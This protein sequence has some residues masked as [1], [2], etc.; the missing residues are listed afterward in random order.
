MTFNFDEEIDRFNSD[1]SKWNT[2]G[3]DVIP[4]W[5][6]DMDFRS[7]P[8]IIDVLH[9]RIDHGVF[10][11]GK[12][13][14]G[15]KDVIIER[16]YRRYQWQI[17]PDW[18]VILPGIVAGLNL[19]VRAFTDSHQA[20]IAPEIIYPPFKTASSLAGRDQRLAP[21]RLHEQRWTIDLDA[22]ED[23]MEG[24]EK[25]LLLCNPQN[26]GGT[27][28]QRDE[29]QQQLNFAKKHDLIVCSDEI[30]SELILCE[31]S[32]HIPFATLGEDAAARS[33]TLVSP[34]KTFNIAGLGASCA[35]IPNPELR[36]RFNATRQGIVPNVDVLALTAAEAAWRDGDP[37]L[38]ALLTYLRAN[39]DIVKAAIDNLPGLHM[40]SPQA[41]YLAWIDARELQLDNPYNFFLKAGVGLS[42]GK[43]FGDHNFVRLN[44]GCTRKLLTQ[45]LLRLSQAVES[46]GR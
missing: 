7:P 21:L 46:L 30:H 12:P 45:S 4:L 11:Y 27:V 42:P 19:S 15:F 8:C 9:K 22:L 5:V 2:Y 35:I 29:L 40:V 32:Q 34:S 6:A 38:E 13:P 3:R 43:S 33:I 18:I 16:F 41:S 39:R 17:D 25:L 37:W 23:K 20:T 24:N 44:F 10:G 28:Y 36:A 26:P 1:S 31:T 14:L